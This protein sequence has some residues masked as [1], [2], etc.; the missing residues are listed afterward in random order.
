MQRLIETLE[1]RQ[2]LLTVEELAGLLSCS[3][4]TIYKQIK[5]GRLPAI[6]FGS[7]VRLD[8]ADVT[9]WIRARKV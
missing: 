9:A 1:K 2:S 5:A 3:V 7:C 6:R 8:P 4:K